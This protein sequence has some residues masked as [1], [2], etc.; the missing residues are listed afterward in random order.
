MFKVWV[1]VSMADSI[2][3]MLRREVEI[4]GPQDEPAPPNSVNGIETADAAIINALF[5]ATDVLFRQYPN[6]RSVA[7]PGA[8]YDN[9]DVPGATAQGVCVLRTPDA[10]SDTTAVFT[11]TLMLNAI[12]RVKRGNAY[13]S[14]G[15]WLPLPG[16]D[17]MDINGATLGI[18]GL[19]RIGARVAEIALVLGM[20]V[21]AYDPYI[22]QGRAL[23]ARTELIPDLD[24]LLRESDVV[25]LH[26]PL[27]DETRGMIDAAAIAK[28][29]DGAVLVNCARGPV[30]V[31]SA[32]IDALQSEKLSAAALD[33]WNPEPPAPDNPLLQMDNVIATPHVASRTYG[34]Q[35]R[36]RLSAVQQTLQVLKGEQP[37]GLVNTEVWAKRRPGS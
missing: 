18:I 19:G 25:T 13:L 3:E 2:L 37:L 5:P 35:Y 29:K 26:V 23:A 4:L 32:L 36:S 30:V 1:G 14:E 31:E 22:A 8:G 28:M 21:I 20:R 17:S 24:T 7:R 6:L 34:S 27:T 9:V 11:I 33:V 15:Q 12:R 10:H 16:L